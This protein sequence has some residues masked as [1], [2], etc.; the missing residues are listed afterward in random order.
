MKMIELIL[1]VEEA[2]GC[3][4]DDDEAA[5]LDTVGKLYDYILAH[6]FRGSWEACMGSLTFCK[7]RRAL[8]AVLKMPRK[9]IRVLTELSAIIPRH[10]RR[11]WQALE[12]AT[13][14]RLPQLRRP[15]RVPPAVALAA[16]AAAITVPML[17]SLTLFN[18]AVAV[19]ILTAIVVG[20]ACARLTAPLA[21]QFQAECATVG[22]LAA[23]TLARNYQAIVAE[24]RTNASDAEVWETLR[25]IIAEQFG[26]RA[27]SITKETHFVRDLNAG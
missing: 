6:R 17:L 4:I 24:S 12:R 26:I 13:G 8:M 18:G 5:S 21:Y 23:G 14:L 19:G 9:D 10:R 1:T 2:F 22:Q 3:S 25:L 27:S 7:L 20:Y 16:I 15:S 11:V